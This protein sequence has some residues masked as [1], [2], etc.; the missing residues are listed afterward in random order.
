LNPDAITWWDGKTDPRGEQ[1]VWK[2]TTDPRYAVSNFGR[3]MSRTRGTWKEIFGT[4]NAS[5]YVSVSIGMSLLVHRAVVLAFDGPPPTTQHT[6]IRH[7][8]GVKSN[9]RLHNLKWGTRSENMQDVVLH[10]Q[11]KA[12][13]E[14]DIKIEEARQKNTWYGGRTWDD[15]L[16]R[17]LGEM[18]QEKLLRLQDVARILGVTVSRLPASITRNEVELAKGERRSIQHTELI[19]SLV[20]EGKTIKEINALDPALI[21]RPLTH[22]D[23]YYFKTSLNMETNYSPPPLLQGEAHGCAKLT[24]AH[25]QAVFRRVENGEF[26]NMNQIQKAL[27]V[28]K[29]QTYAITNGTSWSHLERSDAFKAQISAI[30]RDIL[31]PETQQA[32]LDDLQ[33]GMRR[34]EVKDR[35]SVV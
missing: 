31:S 32:I 24:E 18:H 4:V 6:D 25:I 19:R 22:Q 1:E 23:F 16:I 15:D 17:I 21:G 9:N 11:Q 2:R 29:G 13:A 27:G 26:Q 14:R 28:D 8:D 35:K 10:R 7:L 5:G 12:E 30:R 20:K 33:A 34:N 3:L